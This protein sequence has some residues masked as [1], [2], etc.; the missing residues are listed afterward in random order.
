MRTTKHLS[1]TYIIKLVIVVSIKLDFYS[2]L[3]TLI[4]KGI[5]VILLT[6][7]EQM[8]KSIYSLVYMFEGDNSNYKL[9]I[10]FLFKLKK[11]VNNL[12]F[13]CLFQNVRRPFYS[14]L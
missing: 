8:D 2:K 4:N 5:C 13:K 10:I 12:G 14:F 11:F 6:I 3:S 7:Y 9:K 1:L